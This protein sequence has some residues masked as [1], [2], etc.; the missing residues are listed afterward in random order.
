M[1]IEGAQYKDGMLMLKASGTDAIRFAG[2]FKEPG[3]YELTKAKKLRSMDANSYLWKLVGD[4]A[5]EMRVDKDTV[6]CD[7]IRHVGAFDP[8]AF[9]SQK[10]FDDFSRVWNGRGLGWFCE[11]VDEDDNGWVYGNAFY[12]SSSYDTRQMSAVIDYVVTV[13]QNIGI[14]TDD[15]RI[16]SLLEEWD[17]RQ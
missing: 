1:R 9:Q 11:K 15:G 14:E 17:A 10:V 7:A 5:T 6:Y 16:A 3:E 2:T 8:L 12:G 4:I 13:A